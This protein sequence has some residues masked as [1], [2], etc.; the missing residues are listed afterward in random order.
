MRQ[1]TAL[2][3]A[4]EIMRLKTGVFSGNH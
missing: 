3:A 2:Q 4:K 1:I